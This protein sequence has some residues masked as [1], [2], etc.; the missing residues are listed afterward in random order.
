MLNTKCENFLMKKIVYL[1]RCP[2]VVDWIYT[3]W[4]RQWGQNHLMGL[5]LLLTTD[6]DPYSTVS[7]GDLAGLL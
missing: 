7:K 5:Q 1:W 3:H 6:L 2:L 4:P